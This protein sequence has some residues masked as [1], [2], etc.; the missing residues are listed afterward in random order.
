MK[1]DNLKHGVITLNARIKVGEQI[2][3]T[4][5]QKCVIIDLKTSKMINNELIL[6]LSN[7]R[8]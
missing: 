7:Y 5:E 6:R 3:A 1:F 4:A 2:Y 8:L